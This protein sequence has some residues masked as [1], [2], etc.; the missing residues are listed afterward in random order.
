[1]VESL[2]LNV[3]IAHI[4]PEVNPCNCGMGNVCRNPSC[5]TLPTSSPQNHRPVYVYTCICNL[6]IDLDRGQN[7]LL[8]HIN[9]F[10]IP[11]HG[12]NPN[13]H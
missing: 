4:E 8:F 5:E 3:P 6:L 11:W 12:A 9:G 1:M 2:I 13:D 7:P 10:S